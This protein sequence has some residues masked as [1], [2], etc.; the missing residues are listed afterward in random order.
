MRDLKKLFKEYISDISGVNALVFAI[1]LPAMVAAGG[2]A[3]DL[4]NAYN[5]KNRLGNALDKTAL[6]TANSSGTEAELTEIAQKFFAVNFRESGL[7]QA[8]D[9]NVQFN[10]KV[11]Q[12][13]ASADVELMF[14]GMFGKEDLN[15]SAM[16]EVTRELSGIEV[17]LVLDVTGSMAGSNITALKSASTEFLNIM[18]EDISDPEYIRIGI[19]PYS[20]T[21]N[22]GSYGWGEYP[23]G[24]YYGPAFID[25]PETDDYKT[26]SEITYDLENTHDW[27][28]CVLAGEYPDDVSD[29]RVSFDMYRYPRV[30]QSGW[31]GYCWSYN[32]NP[33]NA[34]TT[35]PVV[36][37]GHDRVLLQDTIDNLDPVGNTLGN[38]GLLWGW[39]L[40]SPE[41]P[42]TEGAAYDDPEWKK[43]VI[44]MTDGVNTMNNTYSAYGR[45]ADHDVRPSDLDDRLGEIC[46]AMKD[47]NITVYTITF[48]NVNESTQDIYRECASTESLYKHVENDS[49]LEELFKSIAN[50]LSR[51]HLSK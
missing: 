8:Y 21:I 34:C 2:L 11:I 40:I 28:G 26:A 20:N 16:S 47:K 1:V 10:D 3:V 17:V 14:M 44:M 12:V 41:E 30:C 33:N 6:A 50:Q 5:V 7:G 13:S 31:Y 39:R 27:H 36:P 51:L 29:E 15:V 48:G 49:E 32:N 24:S 38:F 4:A 37:L 46:M 23:D 18:F 9:L 35:S 42:F 25:L 22:V 45:T 43:A 19:T